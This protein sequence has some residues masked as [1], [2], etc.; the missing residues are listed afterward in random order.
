MKVVVDCRYVRVGAPDGISRFTVGSVTALAARHPLTMLVS[1]RRQLASLP[2]LPHA[3]VSQPTSLREPLVAQQVNRLRPDV[4]FTPMQ[5]MG[6]WRRRYRLV[7]TVHDLIYYRHPKPPPRF[8][9]PLRLLWWLYHLSWWPQRLLLDRA[10]AVVTVSRT[11]EQLIHDHRL[12]RRPVTVVPNAAGPPGPAGA[13]GQPP[14]GNA[15]SRSLVYTGSFMPYKNVDVLARALHELPGFTLHLI[16]PITDAERV[17]LGQLA[18][19][20]SLI[21]HDGASEEDY[22]HTLRGALA[23]VT[24]SRDE[25]F[26]IPL[27]EA[28]TNG[29]PVVVSDIPIFREVAGPAALFADPA[30]PSAFAAAVRELTEPARWRQRS[31][32]G[33]LQSRRFSWDD[34]AERL[35][36]V[37]TETASRA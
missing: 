9:W 25:G 34:S 1:D 19:A 30:D 33:R 37:L 2:D 21:C 22:H 28:M 11:T 14:D 5:T 3:L 31:E 32:L 26:G 4:V 6:S 15:T 35:L 36:H 20:G 16:S 18:P 23:L 12:T 8:R 10:D 27:V 24:A 7:L 17:H 29:I 13:E